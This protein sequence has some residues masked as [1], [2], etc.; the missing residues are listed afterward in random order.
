MK[1]ALIIFSAL[2]LFFLIIPTEADA[3][4]K[5]RKELRKEREELRKRVKDKALKEARKAS[6]RI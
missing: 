2:F 1:K 3:Q 6:C 4:L 5:S